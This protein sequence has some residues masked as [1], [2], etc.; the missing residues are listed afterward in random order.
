MQFV[1]VGESVQTPIHCM[2]QVQEGDVRLHLPLHAVF[3]A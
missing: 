1:H 2:K 3:S